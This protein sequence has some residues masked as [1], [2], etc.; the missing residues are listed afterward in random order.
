MLPLMAF[1][2]LDCARFKR[3]GSTINLP[4]ADFV[5]VSCCGENISLTAPFALSH[6][7]TLTPVVR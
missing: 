4:S 3:K 6:Q 5:S 2:M 7:G 1:A